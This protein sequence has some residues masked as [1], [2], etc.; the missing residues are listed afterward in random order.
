MKNRICFLLFLFL[1]A[2]L[3]TTYSQGISI[4]V[5]GGISIPNLSA[6]GGNENPLNTGYKSRLGPDA[7]LFAEFHVSDLF[8]VQP[9]LE[10]SSQGGKKNG[11]QAFPTPAL[12]AIYFRAQN[13][14]PPTYLYGNFKNEV[15]LS[16][17]M[18]P[19]LAKFTIPLGSSPFRIY[20]DAGP[21]ASLLLA[22]KDRTE[23]NSNIYFDAGGTHPLPG[24]GTFPFNSD[25]SVITSLNKFNAGVE[26]HL[27]ISY[28]IGR[29]SVFVEGGGNY[30][31]INI[32][33]N[34]ADGKNN[35]GAAI[36]MAGYSFRF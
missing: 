29:S 6:P 23:G 16:Y 25:S 5:K 9:M 3:K 35:T 33:K 22:A 19:V 30:G 20:A 2:S 7:A 10:Y 11:L 13:Q 27:G 17:L 21:F 24:L 15:K 8:S 31:F 28:I 32:Q 26:G 4:G 12:A 18:L 1:F 36:I 14:T 34:K